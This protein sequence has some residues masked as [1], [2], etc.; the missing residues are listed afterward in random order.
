MQT[1][2]FEA[3]RNLAAEAMA[4]EA[5]LKQLIGRDQS[6]GLEFPKDDFA[7]RGMAMRGLAVAI[8]LALSLWMVILAALWMLKR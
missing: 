1:E 2:G 5:A 6:A 7:P 8:P 3:G 4:A